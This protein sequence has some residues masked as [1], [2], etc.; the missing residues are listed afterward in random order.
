MSFFSSLE[1]IICNYVVMDINYIC[2]NHFVMYAN[3]KY[4]ITHLK[5]MYVN[6]TSVKKKERE[7]DVLGYSCCSWEID[8]NIF[9][10]PLFLVALLPFRTPLRDHYVKPGEASHQNI[11]FSFPVSLLCLC[12]RAEVWVSQTLTRPDCE[13][14]PWP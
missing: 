9:S 6:Y 14:S 10:F 13:P 5:L 3:N 4:Y 7:R 11:R 1:I 12:D 8:D 2:G